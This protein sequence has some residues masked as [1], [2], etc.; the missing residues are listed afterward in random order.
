MSDLIEKL[1]AGKRN[2]R[3]LAY[4]GIEDEEIGI[5][6]LSESETRDAIFATERIFKDAG[7]EVSAMTV[8]AY[9]AE[10]N[11]QILFRAIVNPKRQKKDG[12]CERLFK[13]VDEFRA[14]LR[15]E[16]KEALIDEYN[17][18]EKECSPADPSEEELEALFAE[19][20]KKGTIPG[21]SSS[22][23]TLQRLIIYLAS[24]PATSQADNGFT[25]S[26]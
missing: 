11:T 23:R 12:T 7:I 8:S 4:P 3:T 22:L 9:T 6:V 24:L 10:N 13:D 2:I 20:K 21:S 19:V 26:L 18:F 17:A 1:K 25:S 16:E 14:L 5:T 15:R